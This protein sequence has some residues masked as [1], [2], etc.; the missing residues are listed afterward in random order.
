MLVLI[1][2]A[3]ASAAASLE[4]KSGAGKYQRVVH[5]PGKKSLP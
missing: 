1:E 4:I 3:I 2:K 5:S